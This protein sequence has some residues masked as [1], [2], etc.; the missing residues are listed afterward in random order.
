M[1]EVKYVVTQV[2]VQAENQAR[3]DETRPWNLEVRHTKGRTGPTLADEVWLSACS[4]VHVSRSV[5]T[6]DLDMLCNLEQKTEGKPHRGRCTALCPI[7]P[8]HGMSACG[9]IRRLGHRPPHV[10]EYDDE[11]SG[12]WG[13]PHVCARDDE[14]SGN[15]GLQVERPE[16]PTISD[17]PLHGLN[18]A[19]YG[20]TGLITKDAANWIHP[21][22]EDRQ[23][24]ACEFEY[25]YAD[26]PERC[27]APLDWWSVLRCVNCG[28]LV[29]MDHFWED[30]CLNC[31]G[32]SYATTP[33]GSD[34]G[35]GK[36]LSLIHI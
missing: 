1:Q 10:C 25:P 19:R 20:S 32:S 12:N 3:R 21:V 34:D 24:I 33:D 11:W 18:V 30:M 23:E 8:R 5:G 29:C 9:C 36:D 2:A 4:V 17:A 26:Q 6:G 13:P 31:I 16:A 35:D 7:C 14:W 27:G 22:P 28:K 15:W